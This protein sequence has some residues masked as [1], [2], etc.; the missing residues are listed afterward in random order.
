MLLIFQGLYS[1]IDAKIE[2]R[3]P[4]RRRSSNIRLP[5]NS[6]SAVAVSLTVLP[7]DILM[8]IS[9]IVDRTSIRMNVFDGCS[10]DAQPC[11]PLCAILS[12]ANYSVS[13]NRPLIEEIGM[14]QLQVAKFS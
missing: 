9:P 1:F 3:I 7:V 5:S 13:T 8:S 12:H 11:G 14:S 10:L 4:D 6:A 2:L